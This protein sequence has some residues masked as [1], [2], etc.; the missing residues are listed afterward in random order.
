MMKKNYE[1]L[2]PKIASEP[3]AIQMDTYQIQ[4]H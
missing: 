1:N 3:T 2:N 4:V